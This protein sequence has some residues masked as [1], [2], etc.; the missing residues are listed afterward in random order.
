MENK[1]TKT[2]LITLRIAVAVMLLSIP[3]TFA[4]AYFSYYVWR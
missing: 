1:M 3:A 4:L 2:Q